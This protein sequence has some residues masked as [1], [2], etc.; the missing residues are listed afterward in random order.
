MSIL[1]PAF[2][3]FWIIEVALWNTGTFYTHF[4]TDIVGGDVFS[5]FVDEFYIETGDGT[6]VMAKRCMLVR[7]GSRANLRMK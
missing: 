6:T 3:R 1:V 5:F 4:S 7:K 2:I